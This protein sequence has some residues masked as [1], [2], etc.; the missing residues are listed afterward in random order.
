MMSR[1]Y[2]VIPRASHVGFPGGSAVKNLLAMQEILVQSLAQED[3]LEK[4][5][6]TQSSILACKI[7]WTRWLVG[8]SPWGCKRVRHN[9][10]IVLRAT[11][12][13]TVPKITV[14]TTINKVRQISNFI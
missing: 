11:T 1:M 10:T 14:K 4:E 9:L 5:M 3:P 12:K 8:Y 6:G 2:I 7:L 13:K